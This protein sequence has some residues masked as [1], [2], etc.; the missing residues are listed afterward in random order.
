MS[1]ST[2]GF[3]RA[4]TC[5]VAA[6]G[7]ALAAA[8]AAKATPL[9][10]TIEVIDGLGTSVNT[11]SDVIQG[12][13]NQI[14]LP[15]FT[16]LGVTVTSEIGNATIGGLINILTTSSTN[17]MNNSGSTA[18]IIAV[19]SGQNFTG[20]GNFA[21]L[22]GSGT[23]VNTPGSVLTQSWY[24]DPTNTLGATT[25][26]DHPGNLLGTFTDTAVGSTSSFSTPAGF[27][28]PLAVP[29]TGPFSMTLVW[30]YTLAN[31]GE[32]VSRGQTELVS[33]TPIAEPGSLALLGS[34]VLALGMVAG[35]RRRHHG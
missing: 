19:L 9:Q 33:A 18:T 4:T 25:P 13:P 5:L 14:L 31:G 2:A 24:N 6:A 3:L 28:G 26:T 21:A 20:P 27:G 30:T 11:I 16:S 22:S 17:I 29:D 15:N 34:G 35:Q 7:F 12:T 23:W 32:L 8:G 1:P 10:G